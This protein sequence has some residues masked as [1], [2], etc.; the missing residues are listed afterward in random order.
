MKTRLLRKER[1]G[2]KKRLT[3]IILF[4]LICGGVIIGIHHFNSSK[5]ASKEAVL[6]TLTQAPPIILPE[7]PITE[8][9]NASDPENSTG[10]TTAVED[11]LIGTEGS[12]GIV[13]KNLNTN[14]WFGKNAHHSYKAGS[15]YKLWVLAAVYQQIQEGKLHKEMRLSEQVTVLNKKFEIAPQ[16]AEKKEGTV[17]YTIGEALD[18][19]ITISDNY[20][21]LLLLNKI[22][23]PSIVN[24]L[25]AQGFSE[26][27]TGVLGKAPVTSPFDMSQY[28]E[29]LVQGK[30]ANEVSTTEMLSLLKR[31]KLNEKMPKYI[32]DEIVIAH[33]TGELDEVTHDA[34]IVYEPRGEYIFVALSESDSREQ[35]NERIANVSKNVYEYFSTED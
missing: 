29:K 35:A 5:I 11:A 25:K 32:P 10:L 28:F 27:K 1:I 7:L 16:Y 23:T 33:K 9:K 34:G 21:A 6:S 20:A 26:S 24:F 8:E 19:M 14:E 31:Q 12:Y 4:V 30:L 13:I 17:S 2:K 18:Q 22:G 15:L 3:R